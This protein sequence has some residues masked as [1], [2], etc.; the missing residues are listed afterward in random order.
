MSVRNLILSG[1]LVALMGFGATGC[2]ENPVDTP[3]NGP[4]N[5]KA[6]SMS[7]TSVALEWDAVASATSYR[8]AWQGTGTAGSGSVDN[9]TATNYTV[10]GL[11]A[12]TAYTFTVTGNTSTGSTDASTLTWAGATRFTETSTVSWPPW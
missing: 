3:G 4:A 9:V 1:A 12:N 6:S 5:L 8:V 7:P 11:Q 2:N 10:T